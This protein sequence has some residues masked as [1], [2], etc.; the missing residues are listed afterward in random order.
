MF[1]YLIILYF[2]TG[3]LWAT[4]K[5]SRKTG[6]KCIECHQSKKG[7]D[8]NLKQQGKNYRKF[9]FLKKDKRVSRRKKLPFVIS[10]AEQKILDYFTMTE[11]VVRLN[12]KKI[13][14]K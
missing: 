7:G 9:L 8:K 11:K 13:R 3:V 2:C 4:K 1:K 14:S 12:R 6:F 10:E 5:Y